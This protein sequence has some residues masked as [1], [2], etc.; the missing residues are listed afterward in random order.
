[1][2]AE[3]QVSPFR[4]THVVP[5]D[6][7][8]AWDAPGSAEPPVDLDPLLPVQLLSRRGDW[9]EILCSNGWSAWV[10]GRLLV[11]VP[12]PPPAGG[13]H[14]PTAAEDPLPLLARSADVLDRYR[15]AA[16]EQAAGR[17]DGESFRRATQGL[18]AGIVVEGEAVWVYDEASRRWMYADGKRLSGYAVSDGPEAVDPGGSGSPAGPGTP[19]SG[20]PGS[21]AP[22]EGTPGDESDED[23]G[24]PLPGRDAAHPPTQI[25]RRGEY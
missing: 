12:Q 6:G 7:M 25:A 24:S 9:G 3:P 2:T 8:S 10:D 21:A 4:P 23:W 15:R 5:V 17:S 13:P 11:A 18:R 16:A 19:G 20:T 14:P 22:G 1:M